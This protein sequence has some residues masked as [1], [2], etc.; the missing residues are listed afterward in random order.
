MCIEFL[1][2]QEFK[3]HNDIRVDIQNG[4]HA[5]ACTGG[6]IAKDLYSVMQQLPVFYRRRIFEEEVRIGVTLLTHCRAIR[7]RVRSI[8][9]KDSK[10]ARVERRANSV[11]SAQVHS[12]VLIVFALGVRGGPFAF[13]RFPRLLDDVGMNGIGFLDRQVC[14]GESKF[15]WIG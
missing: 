5:R 14:L 13:V 10:K 12:Q 9:P 8:P 15:W 7:L 6:S 11:N 3:R 1:A 4:V 2:P